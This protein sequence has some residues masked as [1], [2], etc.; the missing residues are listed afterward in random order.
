MN[1]PKYRQYYDFQPGNGTRYEVYISQAVGTENDDIVVISLPEFNTSFYI[2]RAAT[3]TWGYVYEKMTRSDRRGNECDAS[4]VTALLSQ[5]LG[6]PAR[7]HTGDDGRWIQEE[8]WIPNKE[9]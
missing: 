5:A 1:L 9:P 8:R 3:L 4:A 7:V 6:I 2:N